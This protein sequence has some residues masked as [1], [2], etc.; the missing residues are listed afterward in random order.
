M[1]QEQVSVVGQLVY[2]PSL[3]RSPQGY[4]EINMTAVHGRVLKAYENSCLVEIISANGDR[5]G[6]DLL[7]GRTVISMKELGID[8]E[9]VPDKHNIKG[10]PD[11]VRDGRM[12]NHKFSDKARTAKLFETKRKHKAFA[13]VLKNAYEAGMT[14]DQVRETYHRGY[15]FIRS[16]EQEYN[17]ER[18]QQYRSRITLPDGRIEYFL[19]RN[20]LNEKY[21]LPQNNHVDGL[22]TET[23]AVIKAGKWIK[24]KRGWAEWGTVTPEK[25]L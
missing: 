5:A 7:Q 19:N 11:P 17:I 12:G 10:F 21:H 14:A 25:V 4:G 24:T 13:R 3:T 15:D 2:T 6:I 22:M 1:T 23:G 9:T 18:P 8:S 20:D 16:V